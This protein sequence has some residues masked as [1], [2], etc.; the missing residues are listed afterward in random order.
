MKPPSHYCCPPQTRRV[1]LPAGALLVVLL[2]C[3][4]AG[5]VAQVAMPG[6]YGDDAGPGYGYGYGYGD[7][8]AALVAPLP[9]QVRRRMLA[10]VA[11]V[12]ES[13]PIPEVAPLVLREAAP[14]E[15]FSNSWAAG[16]YGDDAGAGYGYGYGSY[17]ES[18][19]EDYGIN[20]DADEAA[21][22]PAPMRRLLAQAFARKLRL[23]SASRLRA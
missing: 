7:A 19:G 20:G 16:S 21:E 12:D 4:A 2:A 5:S 1:F 18:Y 10:A 11:A 17:G 23:A 3:A 22:A 6:G 14:W 15:E 8:L 9:A 13:A